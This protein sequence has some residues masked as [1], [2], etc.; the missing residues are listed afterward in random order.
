MRSLVYEATNN[1]TLPATAGAGLVVFGTT[2]GN[3]DVRPRLEGYEG[4]LRGPA[5]PAQLADRAQFVFIVRP[6]ATTEALS[7]AALAAM[8]AFLTIRTLPLLSI[9]SNFTGG[10]SYPSQQIDVS[11]QLLLFKGRIAVDAQDW[12]VCRATLQLQNLAAADQVVLVTT[13]I[14]AD[15][16]VPQ[17]ERE[18]L[19]TEQA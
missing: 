1:F 5:L 18:R 12:G 8:K 10:T 19:G 6:L 15:V 4:A 17:W 11:G 13:Q 9:D 7:L 14:L 3:K 16:R 2:I